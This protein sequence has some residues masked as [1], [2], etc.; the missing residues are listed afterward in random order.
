MEWINPHAMLHLEVTNQDGSK[1]VWIFQTTGAAALRQK[2][3]ARAS[4]PRRSSS[5]VPRTF[6]SRSAPYGSAQLTEAAA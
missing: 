3:L 5:R 2:G 1:A 6:E 4:H